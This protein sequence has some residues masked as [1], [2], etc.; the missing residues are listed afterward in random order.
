MVSSDDQLIRRTGTR[1][2][3]YKY[4]YDVQTMRRKPCRYR[5]FVHDYCH[6]VW[7]GFDCIGTHPIDKGKTNTQLPINLHIS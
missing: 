4:M 2:A 1:I 3:S 5:A 7:P 6:S